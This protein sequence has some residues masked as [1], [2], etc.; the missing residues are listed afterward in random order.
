[1]RGLTTLC[2]VLTVMAVIACEVQS[3]A[4]TPPAPQSVYP[5][6]GKFTPTPTQPPSPLALNGPAFKLD[7]P[8]V[9]GETRV[10]GA[11]LAHLCD[12]PQLTAL[13]VDNRAVTAEGIAH[14]KSMRALRSLLVVRRGSDE[15]RID[16]L[17]RKLPENVEIREDYTPNPERAPP[18]F[19]E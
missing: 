18:D 10:T 17:R 19:F 9:E 11:G 6:E 14:L 1:M 12:L 2:F 16:T 8:L 5:F 3:S 4:D 13:E 7:T 15:S